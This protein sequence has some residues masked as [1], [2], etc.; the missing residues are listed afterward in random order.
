MGGGTL[1]IQDIE[2]AEPVAAPLTQEDLILPSQPHIGEFLCP[3]CRFPTYRRTSKS[4]TDHFRDIFYKCRNVACG[5]TFK[6]ALTIEYIVTPSAIPDPRV[7]I[8]VR[9][10]ERIP[11]V[12]VA[13][14][15]GPPEPDPNQFKLFE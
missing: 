3:H 4:V 6:A 5:C 8:P 14:A 9:V 7:T 15:T 1:Q 11:G 2:A 10:M 13:S 12:T